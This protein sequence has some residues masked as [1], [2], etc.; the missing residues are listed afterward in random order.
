MV[1]T[2]SSATPSRRPTSRTLAALFAGSAVMF[3]AAVLQGGPLITGGQQQPVA[4]PLMG[5]ATVASPAATQLPAAGSTF[6]TPV[7][8]PGQATT[9]A[10]GATAGSSLRDVPQH[11]APTRAVRQHGASAASR[12][13][14]NKAAPAADSSSSNRPATQPAEEQHGLLD[15][16]LGYLSKGFSAKMFG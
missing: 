15:N 5:A 14:G 10:P 1:A 12:A 9:W 2:Y 11:Q 3:A 16:V 7:S 13:R 6:P 8:A 4:E